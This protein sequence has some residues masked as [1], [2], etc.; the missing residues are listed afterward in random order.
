MGKLSGRGITDEQRI[1]RNIIV[2]ESGCWEWQRRCLINTRW[3][4][5][6]YGV[7]SVPTGKQ[8]SKKAM[9]HRVSYATFVGPIPEGLW[10]LHACDNTLCCNPD[11]LFLG[12][13][14][15]NINDCKTKNRTSAG[16]RHWNAKITAKDAL[17]IRRM[18]WIFRIPQ[19]LIATQF[20]LSSASVSSIVRGVSWQCAHRAT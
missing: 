14:L 16:D 19:S 18:A 5:A 9:A 17:T 3:K 6:R 12:N 8:G 15:D 1:L 10:V 4:K 7:V 2:V 20:N 13:R 11:H